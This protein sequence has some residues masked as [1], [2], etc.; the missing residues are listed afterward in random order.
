MIEEKCINTVILFSTLRL[1]IHLY[2]S[3]F[4]PFRMPNKITL[5]CQP[6]L[7]HSTGIGRGE[8]SN[9]PLVAYI[10]LGSCFPF[11]CRAIIQVHSIIQ[12]HTHPGWQSCLERKAATPVGFTIHAPANPWVY[13]N[14]SASSIYSSYSH[15]STTTAHITYFKHTNCYGQQWSKMAACWA[16]RL[17]R[18]LPRPR[19]NQWQFT[20]GPQAYR[21]TRCI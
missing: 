13:T 19:A 14:N 3:V 18:V 10:V 21:W 15:S 2:L 7:L 11:T 6:W 9:Y 12:M 1:N 8:S 16:P 5:S 4:S 20:T 17:G